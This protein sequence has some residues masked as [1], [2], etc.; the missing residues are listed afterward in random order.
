MRTIE[1]LL[2]GK[3]LATLDRD[4]ESGVSEKEMF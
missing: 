3:N 1:W 4:V 2:I